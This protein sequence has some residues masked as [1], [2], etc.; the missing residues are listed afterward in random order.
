M[1]DKY[2]FIQHVVKPEDGEDNSISD[3][4]NATQ[5]F[6][7]R[8]YAEDSKSKVAEEEVRKNSFGIP[9]KSL[10][11][12]T[13]DKRERFRQRTLGRDKEDELNNP[14][15]RYSLQSMQ[16]LKATMTD[17][18]PT[19]DRRRCTKWFDMLDQIK[20]GEKIDRKKLKSRARKGIPDSMR[21]LAWP[22]LSNS[23]DV[24][25]VEHYEGGK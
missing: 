3:I 1:Q 23:D 20:S 11:I 25:P 10:K 4:E 5:S 7:S 16:L 14:D 18:D 2:G 9:D 17:V 13:D 12:K 24:V 22:I 21:G 19:V 15:M 6:R 8:R